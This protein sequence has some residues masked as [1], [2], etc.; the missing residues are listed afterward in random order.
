MNM[1]DLFLAN[2]ILGSN[3]PRPKYLG[4][5]PLR[6]VALVFRHFKIKINV[7]LIPKTLPYNRQIAFNT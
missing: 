7:G 6:R 5:N 3:N 2:A 1:C 4:G